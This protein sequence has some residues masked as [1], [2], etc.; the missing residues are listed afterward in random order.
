LQESAEPGQSESDEDEQ[1][2]ET[3]ARQWHLLL[4]SASDAES[5]APMMLLLPE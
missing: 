3:V 2:D 4:D 5:A 1:F